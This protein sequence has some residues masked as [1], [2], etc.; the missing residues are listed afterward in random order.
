MVGLQGARAAGREVEAGG[1][2]VG[3]PQPHQVASADAIAPPQRRLEGT[4]DSID[5]R[6]N[7]VAVT[8]TNGVRTSLQAPAAL[9]GLDKLK[10]GDK[11]SVSYYG[12][13]A[14]AVGQ[15]GA[16]LPLSQGDLTVLIPTGGGKGTPTVA[17][18]MDQTVSV[19][20]YDDTSHELAFIAPGGK[21]TSVMVDD[22]KVQ[23]EASAIS[24]GDIARVVYTQPVARSIVP[25]KT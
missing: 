14:V 6:Q 5:R 17:H 4:I 3:A 7:I 22:K 18:Q 16:S 8:D 23:N 13:V 21:T 9:R 20:S 12:S 25:S 24:P 1:K 19:V 11:V 10:E 15:P 2:E